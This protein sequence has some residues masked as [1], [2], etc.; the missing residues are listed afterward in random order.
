MTTTHVTAFTTC[1]SC[2]TRHEWTWEEAFDKFGFGDGDGLVMT[3]SV[4][5]VLIDAGYAVES[6]QWGLHNVVITS[7]KLDGV[8]QIPEGT[9]LG[10]DDPRSYLPAA[11]VELLDAKVTGDF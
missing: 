3:D 8:E 10:Y 2:G 4:G 11:V 6:Q 7:I 9:R 1:E 5:G